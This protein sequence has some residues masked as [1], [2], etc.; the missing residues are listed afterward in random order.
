M[1]YKL[2]LLDVDGTTVEAK[3]DARPSQAVID[4][5]REASSKLTVTLATGRSYDTAKP[6]IDLLGLDGIGVVDGGSRIV[7]MTSGKILHRVTIPPDTLRTI[8][9][10]CLPFG[11]ELFLRDDLY[12]SP[13]NSID[14]ITEESEKIFINAV[15]HEDALRIIEELEAIDGI[16]AHLSVSWTHPDML[17]IDITHH[18]GTKQHGAMKLAE[19]LGIDKSEIIAI[20]DGHN[21]VPLMMAAGYKVAMGNAPKEVQAIA[22]HV[23]E[24]VTN[25]GVATALNKLILDKNA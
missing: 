21:D 23:T 18:E 24:S 2:L 25:D 17:G 3:R 1:N 4:S 5:V 19:M 22:D 15:T 12:G 14:K 9:T 16:T 13:I 11:Y 8:I 20:G 6:I 10:L 7:E